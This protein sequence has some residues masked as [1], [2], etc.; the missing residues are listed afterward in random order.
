M[1]PGGSGQIIPAE[2]GY[3]GTSFTASGSSDPL[4]RSARA[5]LRSSGFLY[6]VTAVLLSIFALLYLPSSSV[7]SSI[8]AVPMR[9]CWGQHSCMSGG[10][11]IFV[12][13]KI[14]NLLYF[15]PK[16]KHTFHIMKCT[17]M[18]NN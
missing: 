7:A 4:E 8:L 2:L 5:I 12:D 16:K 18:H 17:H 11:Q 13:I 6:F 9:K 1:P 3:L 15:Q 14:C 10:K